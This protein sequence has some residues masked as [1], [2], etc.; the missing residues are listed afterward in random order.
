MRTRSLIVRFP[1]N[2]F[3][4]NALLPD[5]AAASVAGTLL[6]AGHDTQVWDLGTVETME[7]LFPSKHQASLG[8]VAER[9]ND[10]SALGPVAAMQMLWQVR[11]ADKRYQELRDLLCE[12]LAETLIAQ[13]YLSF[14]AFALPAPED[15][16]I[17]VQTAT[18]LRAERPELRLTAFGPAVDHH[19]EAIAEATD[20]FDCFVLSD[21]EESLLRWAETNGNR[22]SWVT[23]PNLAYRVQGKVFRT[24]RKGI[25]SLDDLPLPAYHAEAYPALSGSHK[26]KL[27]PIEDSRGCALRCH[28]CAASGAGLGYRTASP[29]HVCRVM[30]QA[31]ADHGARAFLISGAGST[32]AQASAVASAVATT[33]LPIEY[34]RTLSVALAEPNMF[35]A[36]KRSGCRG[37]SFRVDTGSQRLLQNHYGRGINV[38]HIEKVL[39]GAKFAGL[40]TT[41]RFTFPCPGDDHHTQ[42][43]TLRLITRAGLD[44]AHV[45]LPVLEEGAA[46]WLYPKEFGFDVNVARYA[47]Q[48]LADR[49]LLPLPFDRLRAPALRPGRLDPPQVLAANETLVN[50]IARRGVLVW[51]PEELILAARLAGREGD[52]KA[53]AMETR[54]ALLAGEV[55]YVSGL[56]STINKAACLPAH[57]YALRR[58]AQ[59]REAVGN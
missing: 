15:V 48:H 6:A 53:F 18:R 28:A 50:D 36:L 30:F 19:L 22:V 44:A 58:Y 23:I 40:F 35:A 57:A 26:L 38:S 9:F 11:T 25:G 12:E 47:R 14:I 32:G 41:G 13:R 54:R 29:A 31:G 34:T 20:V 49:A 17:A 24:P 5:H 55:S 4:L 51:C 3:S 56:V 2:P 7:R 45:G 46:W 39:R 43:E 52:E 1:G 33:G 59:S 8:R 21:A 27:F 16:H 10:E 42:D 37:V